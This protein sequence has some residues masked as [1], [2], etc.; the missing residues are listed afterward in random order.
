MT[1][2]SANNPAKSERLIHLCGVTLATLSLCS[3]VLGAYAILGENCAQVALA[4]L[5]AALTGGAAGTI[6]DRRRLGRH[7]FPWILSFAIPLFGGVGVYF[8]LQNMKKP[9]S[10]KLMEE[11]TAY[12]DDAASFRESVPI[13]DQT[14]PTA[15]VPLGDVLS[16]TDS[17]AEQRIAIEYLSEMETPAAVEVLRKAA[18]TAGSEAYF[19]S[20]TAL[21]QMEDKMLARLDELEDAIKRSGET[22]ADGD[23]LIQTAAAYL[24]FIY[25]HFVT[26]E[27]RTEYLQRAQALLDHVLERNATGSSELDESLLLSGRVQLGMGNARMAI[28][29]FNRYIARN[30]QQWNGYLWRAEAWYRSGDYG[31]V[32]EDCAKADKISGITQNMRYVTD[33]WLE[34]LAEM[35]GSLS[36]WL[37]ESQ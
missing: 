11:Y 23:L 2:P 13:T 26:G 8:L 12:L 1:F 37:A 4:H 29:Y 24:D 25:Y 19:F 33:F 34:N 17:E 7:F 32:R 22:E 35:E 20:M 6:A 14:A 3:A 15:P 36:R 9:W 10:G 18:S 21:T 16:V 30:P 27:T 31:R 28:K 5:L